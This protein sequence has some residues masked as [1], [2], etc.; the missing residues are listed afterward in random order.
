MQASTLWVGHTTGSTVRQR[1]DNKLIMIDTGMLK[2]AYGGHPIYAH[3]FE[4]RTAQTESVPW[5]FINATTSDE[6]QAASVPIRRSI[7]P[8][9]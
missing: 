7:N 9:E 5:R 8:H 6:V 1:F 2:E 3:I 4:A